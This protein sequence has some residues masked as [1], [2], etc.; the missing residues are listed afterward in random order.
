M[1]FA[2]EQTDAGGYS[3]TPS[4]VPVN[5]YNPDNSAWSGTTSRGDAVTKL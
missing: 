1:E 5:P 3:V 2:N 4:S